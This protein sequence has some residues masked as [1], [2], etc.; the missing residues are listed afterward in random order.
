[1]FKIVQNVNKLVWD[2]LIAHISVGSRDGFPHLGNDTTSF[3]YGI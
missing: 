1:M 3:T 2:N